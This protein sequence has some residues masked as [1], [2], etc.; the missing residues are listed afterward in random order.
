[1]KIHELIEIL[2]TLDGDLPVVTGGLDWFGA[3]NV[4]K[5]MVI[6]LMIGGGKTVIWPGICDYLIKGS[7]LEEMDRKCIEWWPAVYIGQEQRVKD[8]V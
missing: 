7:A 2:K 3:I 8:L 1:M 6:Q 4:E 5:D